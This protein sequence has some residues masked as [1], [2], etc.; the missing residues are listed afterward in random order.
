MC[1]S[2]SLCRNVVVQPRW[3]KNNHTNLFHGAKWCCH[4]LPWG[5]LCSYELMII[6]PT[7]L[8]TFLCTKGRGTVGGTPVA[9]AACY[10]SPLLCWLATNPNVSYH[11]SSPHTHVK[12][13]LLHLSL[14]CS[15]P[16]W[17]P[18]GLICIVQG[19]MLFWFF[20]F[21]S[22]R[23]TVSHSTCLACRSPS[24]HLSVWVPSV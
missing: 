8:P 21:H 12:V 16:F 17:Y 9:L 14:E 24:S 2:S 3:E 1:T 15:S 22:F 10:R 4:K 6:G 7:P 13:W 20:F 11:V 5:G 23:A 19:F 18:G